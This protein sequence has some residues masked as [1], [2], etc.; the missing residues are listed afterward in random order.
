MIYVVQ[1]LNSVNGLFWPDTPF[2]E[3]EKN[4]Y[5]ASFPSYSW[6][7]KIST[8]LTILFFVRF[9]EPDAEPDVFMNSVSFFKHD[10]LFCNTTFDESS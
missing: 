2:L 5:Q 10:T 1:A 9:L 4:Y 6:S 7:E 8:A 3:A